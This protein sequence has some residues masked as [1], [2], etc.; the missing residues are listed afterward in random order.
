MRDPRPGAAWSQRRVLRRRAYGCWMASAQWLEIRRLWYAEWVSRYGAEPS[1]VVCGGAWHLDCGDLHH[2]SYRN[3]G[4]ERFE[5]LLPVDRACH[6][7][8]HAVWDTNP[9]WRRIDRALANDLI[10]GSLRRTHLE[11]GP[12]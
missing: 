10:I 3:L 9:A 6:D 2:R 7:R 5:D 12:T 4:Q 8:V 11:N 1:C